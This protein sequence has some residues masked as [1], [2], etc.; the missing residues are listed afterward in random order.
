MKIATFSLLLVLV[1]AP[2]ILFAQ[3]EV[4]LPNPLNTDTVEGVI[5]NV[6]GWLTTVGAPIAAVMIII[7]AFQMMFA[8]GSPEK[9]KTGTQTILYTVIGY[10]ILWIARGVVSIIET[11]LQ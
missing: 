11:L 3:T 5:D 7:G 2:N 8:G 6:L 1:L 10:G 4:S 9:F